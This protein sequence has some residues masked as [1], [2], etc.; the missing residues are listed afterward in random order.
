MEGQ[1]KEKQIIMHLIKGEIIA[2]FFMGGFFM[3]IIFL[4]R[5]FNI[6]IGH[7]RHYIMSLVK[8]FCMFVNKL[9]SSAS[10][11]FNIIL[12]GKTALSQ[13]KAVF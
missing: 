5:D 2:I 6:F 1:K 3:K 7:K 9:N 4:F 12:T 8:V 13:D 10:T 11:T